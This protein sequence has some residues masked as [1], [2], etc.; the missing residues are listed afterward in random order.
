MKQQH[1]LLSLSRSFLFPNSKLKMQNQNV[2]FMALIKIS[3][4]LLL[5]IKTLSIMHFYSIVDYEIQLYATNV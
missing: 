3:Q 5:C 4:L 2:I 1:G